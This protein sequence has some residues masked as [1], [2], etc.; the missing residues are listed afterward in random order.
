MYL[1]SFQLTN[2]SVQSMK[3]KDKTE[4]LCRIFMN[5][6]IKISHTWRKQQVV[7]SSTMTCTCRDDFDEIIHKN[8]PT[9]HCGLVFYLYF[10]PTMLI[11]IAVYNIGH[12]LVGKGLILRTVPT[13]TEVFLCSLLVCGKSRSKQGL[14]GIQ[15][16]WG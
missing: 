9:K 13:N 6:F 14:I 10:D 2:L 8:N 12:L 1:Q 15:K 7:I 4:N 16:H 11:E 5:K 3:L